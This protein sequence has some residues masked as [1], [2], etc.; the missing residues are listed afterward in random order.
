[1]KRF[2]NSLIPIA[3]L[4]FFATCITSV[5]AFMVVLAASF[6]LSEWQLFVY[7]QKLNLPAL[8][9]AL[10]IAGMIIFAAILL[11]LS[12]QRHEAVKPVIG[13]DRSDQA[14]IGEV[15]KREQEELRAA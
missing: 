11:G 12:G 8:S 15:R 10:P 4:V 1:M 14:T 5:L 3:A 6:G 7:F 9:I 13:E 2:T